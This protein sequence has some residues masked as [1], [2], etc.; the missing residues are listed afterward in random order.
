MVLHLPSF[1]G[2]SRSGIFSAVTLPKL[3]D[4]PPMECGRPPWEENT[5]TLLKYPPSSALGAEESYSSAPKLSFLRDVPWSRLCIKTPKFV[6]MR[7]FFVPD[8][9]LGVY[10]PKGRWCGWPRVRPFYFRKFHSLGT[11]LS[12]SSITIGDGPEATGK[13]ETD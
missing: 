6:Y 1:E 3:W 5:G 12:P 10:K 13:G 8:P 11:V 7:G 2:L 9:H 4:P